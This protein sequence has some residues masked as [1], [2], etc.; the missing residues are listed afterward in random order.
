MH[1]GR[2]E[3]HQKLAYA[4]RHVIRHRLRE[5]LLGGACFEDLAAIVWDGQGV[6]AHALV[7]ELGTHDPAQVC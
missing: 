4:L 1:Q 6:D 2:T 5:R 3:P 7:A